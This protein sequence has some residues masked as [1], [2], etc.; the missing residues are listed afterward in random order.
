MK[1]RKIG[2]IASSN[3]SKPYIIIETIT[4]YQMLSAYAYS[5]VLFTDSNN[6]RVVDICRLNG[7]EII[8]LY[9][10]KTPEEEDL[11]IIEKERCDILI[12][13]GWPYKIPISVLNLFKAAINCH[14]SI[15]PDYRGSYSYMHYY[16]NCEP[17]YGA[18]I[19]YMNENFDDGKVVVQAGYHR[20]E[21]ED[22]NDMQIRTAE[23][24]GFLLPQALHLIS[25]DYIG[26]EPKGKKRY[27]FK[28]TNEEF[29]EYYTRNIRAIKE[30]R[31][32]VLTPHKIL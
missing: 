30:G 28:R 17:Y 24:C 20:R 13:M 9:D 12:S 19:H 16:A 8:V 3:A 4:K 32:I 7:F 11:R 27:F 29:Q 2:I 21:N 26:Y 10:A 6:G 1:I 18:S 31:E 25:E 23:L 14:G 5:F 22:N 15:L